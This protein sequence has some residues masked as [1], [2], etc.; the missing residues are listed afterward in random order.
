[1]RQSSRRETAMREEKKLSQTICQ[2]NLHF[3]VLVQLH[4]DLCV[5]WGVQL[6]ALF[7]VKCQR[8]RAAC[9]SLHHCS[10]CLIWVS[11]RPDPR[12]EERDEWRQA[13]ANL[14]HSHAANINPSLLI[15]LVSFGKPV[16]VYLHTRLG[17]QCASSLEA[18]S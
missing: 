13:D 9:P 18:D 15:M 7:G 2:L 3:F 16:D 14:E 6:E 5:S 17:L 4:G 1:M 11:C 8:M 12:D 10:W